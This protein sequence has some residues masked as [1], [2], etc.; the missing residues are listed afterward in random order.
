MAT[1]RPQ[2]L[3]KTRCRPLCWVTL[4]LVC[5]AN[6][7]LARKPNPRTYDVVVQRTMFL[8][9]QFVETLVEIRRA[10]L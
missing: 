9:C 8:H 6:P 1:T 7:P 10:A 5:G 4:A 3:S 2:R